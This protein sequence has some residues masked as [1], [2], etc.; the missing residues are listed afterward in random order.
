VVA[1][2]VSADRELPKLSILRLCRSSAHGR[3]WSR[4]HRRP[5]KTHQGSTIFDA[6]FFYASLGAEG[7]KK[8]R[9]MTHASDDRRLANGGAIVLCNATPDAPQS[10]CRDRT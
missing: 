8:W 9:W 7:N 10:V 6:V 2:V 3:L 5:D 1:N 4:R